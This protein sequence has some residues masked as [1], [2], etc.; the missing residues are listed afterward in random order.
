MMKLRAANARGHTRYDWLN[1]YHSFSFGDYFDPH[2]MGVSNLRVINEDWIAPGGGFPTHGHRDMEIVTY[3]LSGALEHRDSLGHGTVIRPGEVQR[4]SAGTGVQ[5]S[6]YNASD[7]EPV[8]LLQIWLQPNRPGV[9]PGYAQR[10]F[11]AEQRRGVLRLLVSPDGRDDSLDAHQ[12][13]LLYASLLERGERLLHPLESE[14]KAYIHLAKGTVRVN[15]LILNG[16]D[17]L[18]IE[19]QAQL[20]IEGLDSAELLLFEL[21]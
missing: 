18:Q 21:P 7:R 17:G 4:M 14:R 16:G 1:S 6:E 15:D 10:H 13:A 3:V 12:E 9:S 20:Q 19:Q 8:H 11:P 5:H 2:A